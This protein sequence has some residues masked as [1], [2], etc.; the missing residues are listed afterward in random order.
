MEFSDEAQVNSL[1]QNELSFQNQAEAE[2][3]IVEKQ[4]QL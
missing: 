3:T 2:T 4:A 1:L